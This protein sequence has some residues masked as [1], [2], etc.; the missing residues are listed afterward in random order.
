MLA[1]LLTAISFAERPTEGGMFSY[2]SSDTVE[3]YDQGMI[4]VHYS[5]SGSNVTRMDD[6]DGTG[7]PD[8]VELVAH[9][10]NDVLDSTADLGFL[11]PLSEHEVGLNDLGRHASIRRLS[12]RLWWKLGWHVWHRRL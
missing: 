10:A 12:G 9:T 1:L 6:L 11:Y 2:D 8:Y 7:A 5:S 3:T 4:R